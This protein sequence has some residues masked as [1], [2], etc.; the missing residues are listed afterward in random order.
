MDISF[1][2]NGDEAR[3]IIYKYFSLPRCSNKD[4]SNCDNDHAVRLG[5][6]ISLL[7]KGELFFSGTREVND[8]F[9]SL[10]DYKFDGWERDIK[11]WFDDF[12]KS[13][14]VDE[15]IKADFR[16]TLASNQK[17]KYALA[18]AKIECHYKLH[19][20]EEGEQANARICCFADSWDVSPMWG[21]YAS[22]HHGVCIGFEVEF[23][24]SG[25]EDGYLAMDFQENAPNGS[26]S[27][28][29]PLLP[30][31]Y[32]DSRPKPLAIFCQNEDYRQVKVKEFLLTKHIDWQYEQERRILSVAD[33]NESI[34]KKLF[35]IKPGVIR[36]VI[37]GL[38]T[39]ECDKA[40]LRP[41]ILTNPNTCIY[42]V[43]LPPNDFQLIRKL[44][45]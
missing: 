44:I 4:S 45:R 7:E 40:Q 16:N 9:D 14:E 37:F 1:Y 13:E 23:F 34:P 26:S 41:Y 24:K 18:A 15:T 19:R 11:V 10:I 32:T 36:E 38:R 20:F 33:I 5:Y 12:L 27:T 30:I 25:S 17:D 42:Q 2:R 35:H 21:H 28:K 39:T 29:F 6:I 43:E 3:E 22:S 8:I 31:T